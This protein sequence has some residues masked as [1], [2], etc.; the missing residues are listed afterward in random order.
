MVIK[1]GQI[2][3][4]LLQVHDGRADL[5][6]WAIII[7]SAGNELKKVAMFHSQNGLY[8]NN[9]EPMPLSSFI[10]IQYLIE[11]GG[12]S[13]S[14]DVFELEDLVEPPEIYIV[15]EVINRDPIDIIIGEVTNVEKKI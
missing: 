10:T 7:D 4:I 9:T 3:P 11:E 12:Y 5:T 1:L 8:M 6:V 15:G 13:L 2:I 14:I